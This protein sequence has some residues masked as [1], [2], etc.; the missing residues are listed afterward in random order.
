[1]FLRLPKTICALIRQHLLLAVALMYFSYPTTQIAAAQGQLTDAEDGRISASCPRTLGPSL[2]RSC[3]DGHR[4]ALANAVMPELS[5]LPADTQ[6]WVATSCPRSL[7]PGLYRSCMQREVAA[8][9]RPGWPSITHLPPNDQQWIIESCPKSLGPT[10]WRACVSGAL[11][12]L[13]PQERASP[14]SL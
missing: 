11:A 10:L 9:K 13:S 7:E 3:L 5:G 12:V 6:Q 1:M 14:G 2:W 4:A 8:L